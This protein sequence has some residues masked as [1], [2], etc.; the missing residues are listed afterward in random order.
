VRR[1][2]LSSIL[3]LLSSRAVAEIQLA[4]SY[5]LRRR[6]AGVSVP[7]IVNQGQLDPAVAYYA[8]TFAGTV[9]VT[10]EGR[11]VYS[12]AA[13]EAVGSTRGW[14]L[15]E[16]AIGGRGRPISQG[17]E[18]ARVSY[19]IGNDPARWRSR[20]GTYEFV[21][22]GEVWPGVSVSLRAQGK[23]LEKLFTVGRGADP[24]RIRMSV[25][26]AQSLR[27]GQSGSL[28]A[29]TGLGEVVFT[30]PAAYQERDGTRRP[31]HVAYR[32]HGRE[33]GFRLGEYDAA[34][35]VVIDPLLQASYLGG[36]NSDQAFALAIHPTSGE[37]FV[38]GVTRS[39]NF[40]GTAGGAQPAYGG[41]DD[42][43]VARLNAA[44]TTVA[45]ATYLGGSDFDEASALAIHPTSG[46]VFVV[47]QTSST[48]FP[49]TAGGTQPVRGGGGFDAFVAR[50]NATLTT[51]A[52]A[53]YLGGSGADFAFALAIHPTSG[54]VFVAGHTN[55]PNFP[56]TAGG[57]QPASGGGSD[58][59]FVARLNAALTTVAQATYLGGSD[60]DEARALA[61]NPTSGE[62]FVAGQTSSTDFPGTAG[63]AQ[64]A[65]NAGGSDAFVARL[66]ATLTT[67]AQATYLGG[68]SFDQALA[69]AI[70]PTSGEV[71][72]AGV[73]QSTDFPGTA[74]GAQPASGGGLDAFV[75]RLNAPLTTLAQATYLG[76]SA[77]DGAFALAIHPTSGEVFVAGLTES[78][79]FPGTAGG[80]QPAS[81][82]GSDA[83]VARLNAPLTTL[84]QATYLGGSGIDRA[85]ALAIHPTST[86]VF[87]AGDT[88]SLTFPGTSS[89]AQPVY[90]GGFSDAFVARMTADL[91]GQPT[92]TPTATTTPTA[93]PTPPAAP[94]A[95]VPTLSPGMLVFLGLALTSLAVLLLRRSG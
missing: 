6:L 79:D 76:G 80:A 89:A 51:L 58:D 56:G 16:T 57:A 86:E 84:A 38:A 45:Q 15:T 60:F 31:V 70:H 5:D 52:Q 82:G 13:R 75:A 12:L 33:Y 77:V 32:L 62:V 87:V 41:G 47:G 21:S 65:H 71:F 66:N 69:A 44:L 72:V 28:I 59:A 73:T 95:N 61:I 27:I 63:G 74:G 14:S 40:P 91:A 81:G 25:A 9:Y 7:F 19:F 78:T 68:S 3:L 17:S 34:R 23:N 8:P 1:L 48:D 85:F 26:G 93:T 18:Q 36:S 20:I 24:S 22:L 49:G 2:G 43:F 30:R 53:T 10:R 54:E 55:S 50:L 94:P 29:S 4:E 88:S 42:A 11:I 83:F 46:E 64:P 35:P 92:P 90:G 67:L 39:L 37:V